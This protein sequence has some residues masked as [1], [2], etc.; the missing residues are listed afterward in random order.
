MRSGRSRSCACIRMRD[1]EIR[2]RLLL[3]DYY[4]ERDAASA[5][6]QIDAA[7]ALLSQAQRKGLRAGVL[8]CQGETFET[9]G[10]NAHA[11]TEFD[12]AVAVATAA[13]D[14]EMLA[15]ALFSR[16]YLRALQGDYAAGMSDVR[17][18]QELFDRIHMPQHALT[19]LN[20]IAT[21]YNKMGDYEQAAQIYERAR[22]QQ[23]DA[24][25]R[26][27]EAV[28]LYNLG[29]ARRKLAQWDAARASFSGCLA[30]S[31]EIN[32]TRGE[33]Y[34]LLGLAS[35]DNANADPAGAL[36]L[37]TQAAELQRRSAGLAAECPDST[38]PRHR[39]T[40]GAARA[41]GRCRRSSSRPPRSSR[42]IR[43]KSWSPP[44]ASS[45]SCRLRWAIGKVPTSIGARRRML[46]RN[47]CTISWISALRLSR[48]NSTR[49]RRRRKT[50]CCSART[51]PMR[52]R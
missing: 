36:R 5:Q 41:R 35:V 27:D 4:S 48:W 49:Q 15:E 8:T 20:T 52:R 12:E 1:L 19:V 28:T 10:D 40:A 9:A 30:L 14:E 47:C 22:S 32:Y 33:A 25:L 24:G 21:I 3:C 6:Q 50:S 13:N 39:A 34:G 44:M 45:R 43:S 46:P 26:R 18:S 31:R 11:R 23:H 51:P 17:R 2:A 37:L 42:P 38:G 29:R 7:N 16:G